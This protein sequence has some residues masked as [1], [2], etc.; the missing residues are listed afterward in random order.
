MIKFCCET[1]MS[2]TSHGSLHKGGELFFKF[3]MLL[4][5]S[6]RSR[7]PNTLGNEND[8]Q[9]SKQHLNKSYR[10]SMIL[11]N[12]LLE[13]SGKKIFHNHS[14]YFSTILSKKDWV[15]KVLSETRTSP[16]W[17]SPY[18]SWISFS[19]FILFYT[20]KNSMKSKWRYHTWLLCWLNTP[21]ITVN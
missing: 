4:V 14:K 13:S 21:Y 6:L 20:W 2:Q 12:Y 18:S 17:Y 7:F 19:V 16:H 9:C 1:D 5:A 15:Q 10:D 11:R 8:L 3:L